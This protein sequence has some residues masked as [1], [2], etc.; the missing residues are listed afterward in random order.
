MLD[1]MEQAKIS[2]DIHLGSIRVT[3]A[4]QTQV[5]SY[6]AFVL[7]TAKGARELAELL[8]KHAAKLEEGE[9]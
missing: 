8:L 2:V 9:Q 4:L 7:T 3:I 1:E 5:P 6:G